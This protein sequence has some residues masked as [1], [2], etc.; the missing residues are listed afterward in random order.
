MSQVLTKED[1]EVF[2]KGLREWRQRDKATLANIVKRLLRAKV[3][4]ELQP[5]LEA[6]VGQAFKEMMGAEAVDKALVG[7]LN[8]L[9]KRLRENEKLLQ[10]EE[11]D[12]KHKADQLKKDVALPKELGQKLEGR[13][14]EY[15]K[16]LFRSFV[17][18]LSEQD[19]QHKELVPFL[20]GVEKELYREFEGDDSKILKHLK[21]IRFSME[22]T[23]STAGKLRMLAGAVPP[24]EVVANKSSLYVAAQS[25]KS[26]D[27]ADIKKLPLTG[28]GEECER[29]QQPE[30]ICTKM[31]QIRASDE[32]MTRFMHCRACDH[33]W[34]D[35]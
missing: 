10:V 6:A 26:S 5:G 18:N 2:S 20:E 7:E 32:P 21:E 13:R 27:E 16:F 28:E 30:A 33:Q 35:N 4:K 23:S 19:A 17:R 24:K 34:T 1:A 3:T 25:R 29:C 9:R 12:L 11:K 8:K 22:P 31:L 14:L 15:L